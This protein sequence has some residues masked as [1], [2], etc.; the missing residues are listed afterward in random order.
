[1]L[2]TIGRGA[3][4]TM[5][6]SLLAACGGKEEDPNGAAPAG[7]TGGALTSGATGGLATGG[8]TSGGFSTGAFATGGFTTG[9]VATGSVVTGGVATGGVATGGFPTG[10]LATGGTADTGGV[11][12]GGLAT[13]GDASGG[14]S[15][16]GFTTGG[17][18]TGGLA[19]GG[20]AGTGGAATGGTAGTGG[21]A[22]GGTAGTGG[23]ADSTPVTGLEISK[24]SLYQTVEIPLMQDW[25]EVTERPADITQGKD[26]LVRIFVRRQA[27]WTSRAVRAVLE[28]TSSGGSVSLTAE[29][30][31]GGDSSDEELGSTLN[32]DVPGTALSGDATYSV[33][34]VEAGDG[35]GGGDATRARWPETGAASVGARS[36]GGG[37]IVR[38]VPIRYDADGSGRLPDTSDGQVELFREYFAKHY[39]VPYDALTLTVT[40][41]M[42][43]SYPVNADGGGWNEILYGLTDFME[44]V[45]A[46]P[47]EYFY[48]LFNPAEREE[49]YCRYSCVAGQAFL[50][51][52]PQPFWR[53]NAGVGLGYSGEY[54]AGTI[55]HELAHLHGR[56]HAPCGVTDADPNFPFPDGTTQIWGY[57]LFDQ[58]LKDPEH[59]DFMGYCERTWASAYTYQGIFDWMVATNTA[60]MIRGTPTTWQSLRIGSDGEVRLGPT[61]ELLGPPGGIEVGVEWL[62]ADLDVLEVGVGYLTP[63]SS[64]PGGIV[65]VRV[66]EG[67]AAHVRLDGSAPVALP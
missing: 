2:G 42:T 26:A 21:A 45:G 32:V 62:D 33:S 29:R 7:G 46:A 31:I 54:T 66:P 43:W 44:Q 34:L 19:T 65:L 11:A 36:L 8:A 39:P 18:P 37:L 9:G 22:T 51:E 5:V 27:G 10:G 48:G 16:G 38:L 20:T 13:G 58:V 40:E 12:T 63:L 6:V 60:S 15:T 24:V 49:S 57:D 47:D 3:A 67:G 14:F 56:G 23:N 41:P 52:S 35:S 59:Y 17:F 55:V 28:I 61:H 30:T 4:W 25:A 50:A 64:L 53:I 1:M